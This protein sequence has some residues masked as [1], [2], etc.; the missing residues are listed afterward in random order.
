M[1]NENDIIGHITGSH[2]VD[3]EGNR[4]EGEEMPSQF[5]I[6]TQA[7]L[8]NS[9]TEAE[10]RERMNKII[11]EIEDGKWFVS[12]ESIGLYWYE[13]EDCGGASGSADDWVE[14]KKKWNSRI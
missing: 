6:I 3:R 14:A 8:Y 7:V 4:V 9:W 1:H 13:C 2:V 5:D 12:M 10:N 11:S